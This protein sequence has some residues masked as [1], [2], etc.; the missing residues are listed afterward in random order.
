MSNHGVA[1]T[2]KGWRYRAVVWSVL[3][4]A[5]GYLSFALWSGWN[6]VIDAATK[7]GILGLVIALLLS[8]VNYGLR[9]V[10]WQL[11]LKAMAHPVHWRPSLKIYLAGFA[12][13]TTP[14]K[15]GE[16]L[17]GVLLKHRGVPYQTSLAAFVSDRLSDL[18]AVVILTLFGLSAYPAA[19]PLVI[20]GAGC[21]L[22][23]FAVF[24]NKRLLNR[25]NDSIKGV[26][27]LATLLHQLL[28]T[29]LQVRR[30]HTPW[31][32]FSASALGVLAWA[33]EAW[34]LHLILQWMGL[35][36]SLGFV[37]F[38]Y[39]VSMLAGAL[40]FTPGGLGSAEVAM[41]TL[42][43]WAGV[44]SVEA[45]AAT[46]LIRV[47]TLWFA[48]FLGFLILLTETKMRTMAAQ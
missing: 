5:L 37:V 32:M 35:D 16:A 23:S 1:D 36:V 41:V 4:A 26:S 18:L 40:S 27:R 42:L 47:T 12:L 2:F 13:T 29:L 15:A 17:R 19:Q 33:A 43:I 44:G 38:V 10:R 34:A 45:T 31:L 48:V 3:V 22:V 8:L 11:Y 7:V 30:C 6:D 20:I 28:E 9:F 39:A 25:L 46:I 21:I 24:W 14:G